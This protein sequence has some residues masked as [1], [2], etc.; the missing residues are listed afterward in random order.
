MRNARACT[1]LGLVVLFIVS[2]AALAQPAAP[3][4]LQVRLI[5]GQLHLTW[6]DNSTDEYQFKIEVKAP[7]STTWGTLA[8][9]GHD[10]TSYQVDSFITGR[11][12]S[13]RV[14][15]C[16]EFGCSAFSNVVSIT[17]GLLLSEF[18]LVSPDGGEAYPA[19]S[20]C[21]IA[22]QNYQD[23]PTRV[24]IDY[25][26]D[27]GSHWTTI[28]NSYP[29]TGF[30]YWLVP[31]TMSADCRIR[32]RN[33]SNAASY[34]LSRHAFSIAGYD[35]D[36]IGGVQG[37]T[38]T[39]VLDEDRYTVEGANFL[40][41]YRD[42]VEYPG[43]PGLDPLGNH[44]GAPG[45]VLLDRTLIQSNYLNPMASFWYAD[46]VSPDLSGV[47]YWQKAIGVE[48]Q[49]AQCLETKGKVYSNIILEVFDPAENKVRLFTH[50][51]QARVLDNCEFGVDNTWNT[52]QFLWSTFVGFPTEYTLKRIRIR[53][54]GDLGWYYEGGVFLDQ[55]KA[56]WP[57]TDYTGDGKTNADDFAAFATGWMSDSTQ[58]T[59]NPVFNLDATLNNKTINVADLLEF[60]KGWMAN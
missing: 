4:N 6:Q 7:F 27:G 26:L 25:S 43:V 34:D 47:E 41:A 1:I 37:W 3:S 9:V 29:N 18:G 28:Q 20:V 13:Y 22:W 8:E 21:P 59:W 14:A 36:L 10:I 40:F 30:F 39:E 54:W 60:V 17:P 38:T 24:G 42:T 44:K 35:F 58:E 45:M 50:P 48:A 51:T 57:K 23:P 52:R 46:F 5:P 16:G 55:I 2:T 19:G 32:V 12:Y 49:I 11:T 56:L 53:I 33:A 31:D 15:A